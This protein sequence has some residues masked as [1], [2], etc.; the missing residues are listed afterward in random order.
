M[1]RYVCECLLQ[2]QPSATL[3]DERLRG[4]HSAEDPDD[5]WRAVVT[6]GRGVELDQRA[7]E[8]AYYTSLPL[9]LLRNIKFESIPEM[10]PIPPILSDFSLILKNGDLRGYLDQCPLSRILQ[11]SL[12]ALKDRLRLP[13]VLRQAKRRTTFR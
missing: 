5:E 7:V 2:K 6:Q 11:T 3:L 13:L 9:H 10:G 12:A 8:G 1:G 4:A